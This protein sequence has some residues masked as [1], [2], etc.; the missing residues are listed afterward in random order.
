MEFAVG[1]AKCKKV[2]ELV[3]ELVRPGSQVSKFAAKQI[4]ISVSDEVLL[5]LLQTLPPS[6]ESVLA[7]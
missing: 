1:L 5:N 4:A 7:N 6:Q 3:A 2:E